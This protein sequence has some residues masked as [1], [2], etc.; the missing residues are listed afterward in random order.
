MLHTITENLKGFL[1]A[2]RG[3][4]RPLLC[5]VRILGR[6]KGACKGACKHRNAK[7]QSKA[8]AFGGAYLQ[9]IMKGI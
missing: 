9:G 3:H 4:A 8:P 7:Q 5:F 6:S 1:C 2:I